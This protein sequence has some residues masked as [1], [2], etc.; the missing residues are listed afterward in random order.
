[1]NLIFKIQVSRK[2][3]P[4]SSSLSHK[5]YKYDNNTS[6]SECGP[7]KRENVPEKLPWTAGKPLLPIDLW[8]KTKTKNLKSALP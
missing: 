5:I 2:K 3:A 1:M 4:N 7:K 8:G 6:S